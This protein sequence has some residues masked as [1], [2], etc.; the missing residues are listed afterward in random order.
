M[1]VKNIA[2]NF[3]S[4]ILAVAVILINWISCCVLRI[5]RPVQGKSNLANNMMKR[6]VRATQS[7]KR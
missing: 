3:F 2:F 6:W 4:S 1:A 5:L 7:N